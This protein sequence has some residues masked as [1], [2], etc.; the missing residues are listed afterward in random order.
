MLSTKK[1]LEIAEIVK[2]G[3]KAKPII[4]YINDDD[5]DDN[6]DKP[7]DTGNYDVLLPKSFYTSL[8]NVNP[9][10]MIMLKKAIRESRRALLGNNQNLLDAYDRAA[11]LLGEITKKYIEIPKKDGYIDV[12]PSGDWPPHHGV[13]GP[14][15]VG[16]STYI[17]KYLKQYH[18][19]FPKRDIYIVSPLR[20]D[21]AFADI[22]AKYVKIDDSIIDDPLEVAE[23][24]DSCIVFD[25]IESIRDKVLNES[26][27]RFRDAVLETG[28]HFTIT[29]ISV[30]HVILNGLT[31]YMS[32]FGN[33]L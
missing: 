21:P 25:D 31:M 33:F 13:F 26:V 28:R 14:S 7:V 30:S 6:N 8:R 12:L 22:K 18:K 15:G 2:K 27:S 16:K 1:G 20:E 10:N 4:I 32:R 9:A 5:I 11:V 24:A 29:C 19:K 17:A 23:F 3:S